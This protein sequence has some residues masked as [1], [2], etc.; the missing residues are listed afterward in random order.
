M[1]PDRHRLLQ[2]PTS[3]LSA[4]MLWLAAIMS[5]VGGGVSPLDLPGSGQSVSG[6]NSARSG[7]VPAQR[8]TA[9]STSLRFVLSSEH[10][11]EAASVSGFDGHDPA[12][13][14]E[15]A[16][17]LPVWLAAHGERRVASVSTPASAAGFRAR[18]PPILA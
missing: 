5:A 11:L 4:A 3:I 14:P 2:R 13:T 7:T 9:Q 18:A 12:L 15:I 16:L 6:Q 8:S 1:K 10:A 17:D